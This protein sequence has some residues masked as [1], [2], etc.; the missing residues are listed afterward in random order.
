MLLIRDRIQSDPK[1]PEVGNT[2]GSLRR[3]PTQESLDTLNLIATASPDKEIQRRAAEA[4]T[5]VD[6]R[7]KGVPP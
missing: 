5:D 4:A 1:D 3:F 2:I 6:Q 7:L